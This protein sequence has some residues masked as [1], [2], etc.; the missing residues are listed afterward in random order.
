MALLLIPVLGDITVQ[1]TDAI[2]NEANTRGG[3][4]GAIHRAG[5]PSCWP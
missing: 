4:G 5:G 3:V 2:V 1:N